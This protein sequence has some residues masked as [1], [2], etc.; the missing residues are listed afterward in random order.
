M[1]DFVIILP[2]HSSYIGITKNFIQL[3]R[4]N[5]VDCPF[6]IVVSATGSKV[7]IEDVENLY[8]GE[9]ASLI[10]CVVN[11]AK[12]YK[13]EYCISFLGDAFINK[14]I[15]DE[16][17]LS[18]LNDLVIKDIQYCSLEYVKNYKKRKNFNDYC[19]YINNLD[20]YSHNFTAFVASYDFIM[21]ELSKYRTDLDFEKAYLYQDEDF[22]F[23]DHLVVTK[24][25]FNLLPGIT[26]GKWDRF[27][28]NKLRKSNPEIKF[29]KRDIQ[30]F[31]ESSICHVRGR[32]VPYMPSSIRKRMKLA[33][34]KV[35]KVKFG[36]EG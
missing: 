5:W 13:A 28:Y 2:T 27:N 22:Y 15:D 10:E 8:N 34:E 18:L 19:R 1:S 3:L 7:S 25:Y 23:D 16:K 31:K 29:A 6:K 36:V 12:K 26:K 11:A 33:T 17:I 32:I 35:F 24:N 21:K 14:K 20:R 30:S 4:K 9:G